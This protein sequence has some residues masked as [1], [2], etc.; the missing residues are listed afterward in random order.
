MRTLS[1]EQGIKPTP[2]QQS[3]DARIAVIEAQLR[4]NSQPKEAN[5]I[6]KKGEAPRETEGMLC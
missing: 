2:K 5:V 6:K 1:E 3:A 4:N